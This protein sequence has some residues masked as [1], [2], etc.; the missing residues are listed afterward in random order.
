MNE[1]ARRRIAPRRVALAALAAL[2][3]LA[4]LVL[5]IVGL[6]LHYDVPSW[7]AFVEGFLDAAEHWRSVPLAPLMALAAFTVGGLIAFPVS[8]MT[9]ATIV[10]FGPW[11]GGA[12]AL[13]GA[14]LNAWLIYEL[15]LLLPEATFERWFGERGTRLRERVV[16]H[17]LVAVII[18][19]LLPIAPYAVVSFIAGA[20]RLR[21]LDFLLG[22][23]I[24]M[25]HDVVLYGFFADRARAALLDPH[26][27]TLL[28]LGA[29]G[30]LLLGMAAGL[31]VWHRKRLAREDDA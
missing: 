16:G 13:L 6:W 19:R 2:I 14:V 17:G 18:V 28:G 25:L 8:W 4:L 20:A 1:A 29:A 15:G 5:L 7:R 30:L 12:Y 21:R 3:A 22:T 31:H 23:A 26:P 11:W 27:L 10:V 24:G 9:A